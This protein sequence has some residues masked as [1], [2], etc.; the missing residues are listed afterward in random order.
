MGSKLTTGSSK[1]RAP[2]MMSSFGMGGSCS[3]IWNFRRLNSLGLSSLSSGSRGTPCNHVSQYEK[4]LG[5]Q[6]AS[7]ETVVALRRCGLGEAAGMEAWESCNEAGDVTGVGS[8]VSDFFVVGDAASVS[9]HCRIRFECASW[10]FVTS[11]R[12]FSVDFTCQSTGR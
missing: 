11:V 9:S 8:S 7:L 6:L 12:L 3:I 10:T 4:L 2:G 1:V 5:I